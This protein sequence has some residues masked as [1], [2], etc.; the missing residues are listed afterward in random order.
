[1]VDDPLVKRVVSRIAEG[2]H[3]RKIILFG[4][5]ATGKARPDSDIDLL[6]VYSG[7]KSKRDVKRDVERL[8]PMRDFSMDL[9]VLTPEELETYRPVANTL[10]REVTE[11]GVVCY[12]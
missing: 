4:S 3:P 12:G 5:R 1:V 2:I 8:F 10:A 6:I 9:F 7:D 11:R